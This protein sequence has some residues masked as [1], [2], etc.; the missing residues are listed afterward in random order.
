MAPIP[1]LPL[2]TDKD[3]YGVEQLEHRSSDSDTNEKHEKLAHLEEI[4][5]EFTQ[6]EQRKIMHRI[7]RRLIIMVGVMYCVSLMD[8]TN[9]SAAAIA[10]M[11]T[12][13]T[14]IGFRYVSCQPL[15]PH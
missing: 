15:L 8:R 9:L 1:P 13:L 6:E 2:R 12:E 3:E 7:D 14:L 11:T 5:A 10:G 4:Q